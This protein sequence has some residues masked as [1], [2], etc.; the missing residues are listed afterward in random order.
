MFFNET[1]VKTG[2]V[3]LTW[4]GLTNPEQNDN[5]TVSHNIGFA[6]A[7]NAPEKAELETL[8]QN[9]LN[10]SEFKGVLPAGANPAMK[11]A[12][13]SKFGVVLTGHSTSNAS[14]TR[15]IPPV[16]DEQG[17]PMSTEQIK[18]ALYPGIEVSILVHAY[19]YNNKQ[20]GVKFGIDGVQILNRTAP[21][22]DVT[23]GMSQ[24]DVAKAFG[25]AS[26][27]PPPAQTP[28]AQTPPAQTPPAQT[29]PP[30]PAPPANDLAS[31]KI[32]LPGANGVPYDAFISQ[33]WTDDQLIAN[34][35]MQA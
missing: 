32:M 15:G 27:A 17:K 25:A 4:D 23:G 33:G 5:G 6:I 18:S 24:N 26:M 7:D 21:K 12:D 8:V 34:G 20:R 13:V 22:L 30:P 31:G 28:P 2:A 14:T 11:P 16:Y 29:P 9:S 3:K 10:A 35:Y 19:T 1:T